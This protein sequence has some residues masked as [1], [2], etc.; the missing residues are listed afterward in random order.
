MTITEAHAP[1]ADG[2][3]T[4]HRPMLVRQM[5]LEADNVVSIELADPTG[6]ALPAWVPGSHVEVRLPSG[7]L[8]QYSLCGPLDEPGSYRI[9]VLREDTGRG[10]S[11][12]IHDQVRVGAQVEVSRP[13]DLFRV[14]DAAG[15]LCLAGGIGVT[16]ILPVVARAMAVGVPVRVVYGGRTASAMAFVD[17]LVDS[18]GDQLTLVPQDEQGIPDFGSL[19]DDLPEGWVVCACGPGAM[20][21]AVEAACATRGLQGR[22]SMERFSAVTGDIDESLVNAPITVEL[23]RSGRTVE[24]P[25]DQSILDTIKDD[26]PV[27]YS[28]QEGYCGTCEVRV[29]GGLPDHRDTVLTDEEREGN[30][31]MMICV[32][33]A[34]DGLLRLDL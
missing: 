20:L 11:L 21:E 19:L 30:E 3:A 25:A 7:L 22:L 14:P 13:R 32:S 5:R 28:C 16:P 26:A 8:R 27:V 24:V 23:V 34:K 9:A 18:L 15:Y 4:S 10:G 1:G 33:R 2:D 31:S 6:D 17:E 29:L 12:E